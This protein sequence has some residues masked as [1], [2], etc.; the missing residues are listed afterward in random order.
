MEGFKNII[1]NFE[2][3]MSEK[4]ALI[5]S[6]LSSSEDIDDLKIELSAGIS[7]IL[8][9]AEDKSR[10]GKLHF[11]N[12]NAIFYYNNTPTIFVNACI[13][14]MNSGMNTISSYSVIWGEKNQLNI[15]KLNRLT[16]KTLTNSYLLALLTVLT[17]CQNL[18]ISRINIMTTGDTIGYLIDN[19][20]LWKSNNFIKD[21]GTERSDKGLMMKVLDLLEHKIK[22]N[23]IS[24]PNENLKNVFNNFKKWSKVPLEV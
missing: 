5:E 11:R 23:V 10:Y 13:D 6:S 15:K 20:P 8:L 7:E 1:K 22:L 18:D 14:G 9:I 4:I 24:N 21:D 2:Q 19:L 17:Q 12:E 3:R 16:V